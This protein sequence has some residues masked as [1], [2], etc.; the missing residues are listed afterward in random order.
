MEET[1][2]YQ[3]LELDHT[4]D[5][6]QISKSF[7]RLSLK[8]HPLRN[9]QDQLV[10]YLHKFSRVCEAF[11]VLYDPKTKYTY[12]TYGLTGLRN[13][14]AS[15]PDECSPYTFSGQPHKIFQSMFSSANPFICAVQTTDELQ[16]IDAKMRKK[17]VIVTVMCTLHELYCGALKTVDY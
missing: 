17:D 11:E 12:D 8:Y 3:A 9:D 4:A 14:I 10:H 1:D 2:Y 13:G 16:L 15:G 6:E 5:R 7:A